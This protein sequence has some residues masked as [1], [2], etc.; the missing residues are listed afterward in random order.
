M[1]LTVRNLSVEIA[2]KL[3]LDN[4]NITIESGKIYALMGPNGSGK[5]TLAQV[6]MG[7]PSYHVK[8]SLPSHKSSI[9]IGNQDI[10]ELSPDKRARLGLFLAFQNPVSVSGV[11]VAN[12]LRTAASE[13]MEKKHNPALNV[14]RFNEELYKASQ[15]LKIQKELL[16]RSL[17]EDLSGGEKKKLEMLQAVSLNPKF[18]VFDEIDTG[19]DVDA[20]TIVAEG[21]LDL[22][23]KGCGILLITHYQRILKYARP[24]YVYILINGQIKDKG[25]YSLAEI[26]EKRGFK[27][28][29]S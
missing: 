18:A 25:G 21:I 3:V 1:Y 23:K 28:W 15:K 7:H 11:N 19:L 24:D 17:N 4:I 29:L 10:L 26:V 6:L 8:K 16:G 27:K 20:L 12:V 5:S 2:G 13:K 9:K 22:K 14:L